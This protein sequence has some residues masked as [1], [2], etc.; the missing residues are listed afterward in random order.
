MDVMKIT[1]IVVAFLSPSVF[2]QDISLES[3]T[4]AFSS[5]FRP[6]LRQINGP[7]I[8]LLAIELQHGH[9]MGYRGAGI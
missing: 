7:S 5:A 4:I 3:G 8:E 9:Q 2:V 1:S 6:Q